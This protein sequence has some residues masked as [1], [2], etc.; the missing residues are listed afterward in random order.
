[1]SGV[2]DRLRAAALA[3]FRA[4][5]PRWRERLKGAL[6]ALGHAPGWAQRLRARELAATTKRLDNWAQPLSNM[7]R[8][9]GVT[10]LRGASCLEF[11]SGHLLAEP[12]LYHLVGARR[13]VAVDYF[14]ILQEGLLS[15]VCAGVDE[16]AL[17]ATLAPFEAPEAVR[18]RYHALVARR[19][20]SLAGLTELGIAYRA[21]YDAAAGPLPG[22]SF[23]LIASCSVLEHV[24]AGA[25]APILANLAAMLAPGGTMLHAIHLEDHRDFEGAPF[26][27]LAADTDWTEADADKRGNR[28]RASDWLRIARAVPG[29]EI[30]AAKPEIRETALPARLDPRFACYDPDD[31]RT[32]HLVLALRRPGVTGARAS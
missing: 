7:L 30:V 1:M 27:F 19:D 15:A 22:E 17:V 10:S 29:A 11:G 12:L 13:V 9:A 3:G 2:A 18:A 31:L 5:P 26:A 20:W 6:G 16:E 25:A 28:L 32:S 4:L 14:P 8:T 23:D 24:P 21:P